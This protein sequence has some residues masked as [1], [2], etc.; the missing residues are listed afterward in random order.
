M[1][2]KTA[3]IIQFPIPKKDERS[4]L[5]KAKE[6]LALMDGFTQ[7]MADQVALLTSLLVDES[8]KRKTNR[9]EDWEAIYYYSDE[10]EDNETE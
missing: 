7:E 10:D 6:D 9:E 2:T 5:R 4:D 3:K 1:R 8:R